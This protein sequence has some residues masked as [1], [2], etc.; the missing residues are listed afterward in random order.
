M[1]SIDLH[2]EGIFVVPV[3]NIT[4]VIPLVRA[5]I[6]DALCV[7][8]VAILTGTA[9][10]SGIGGIGQV[11]EDQTSST[12]G[13]SRL[14]TNGNSV[15]EFFIDDDVVGSSDRQAGKKA[16][17]VGGGAEVDRRCRV[18]AEQLGW[19]NVISHARSRTRCSP[20]WSCQRSEY[21][22]QLPHFQ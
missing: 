9:W 5:S 10:R 2:S 7:M 21:C 17:E 15:V 12:T 13:I 14:R 1:T 19:V 3:A 22:G 20:P 16:G 8:D 11:E 18:Q 6:D 4:A